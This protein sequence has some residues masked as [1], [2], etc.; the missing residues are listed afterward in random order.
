M[1]EVFTEIIEDL[2]NYNADV[3]KLD[4]DIDHVSGR[5][6]DVDKEFSKVINA[7]SQEKGGL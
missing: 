5:V 2:K 7:V 1:Q 4:I 6:K 3:D